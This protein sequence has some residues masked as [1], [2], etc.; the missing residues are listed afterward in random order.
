MPID[1]ETIVAI[2]LVLLMALAFVMKRKHKSSVA[3]LVEKQ[4]LK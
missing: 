4:E 3:T 2:A 1:M